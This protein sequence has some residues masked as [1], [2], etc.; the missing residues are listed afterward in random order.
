MEN[1]LPYTFDTQPY[2]MNMG[3]ID[4]EIGVVDS[5]IYF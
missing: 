4:N 2:T 3:N 5:R 1:V